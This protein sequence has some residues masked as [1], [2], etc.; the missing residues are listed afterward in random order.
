GT[1]GLFS[2]PIDG[3]ALPIPLV[4]TARGDVVLSGVRF[5]PDGSALGRAALASGETFLFR[6]RADEARSARP[7]SGFG[8][9]ILGQPGLDFSVLPGGDRIV[10]RHDQESDGVVELFLGFLPRGREHAAQ[11]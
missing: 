6:A 1:V 11:R 8:R 2:T 5:A 3:S 9:W 4:R 10:Y 7:I